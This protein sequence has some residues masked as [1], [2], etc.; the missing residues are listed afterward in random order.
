M[1]I[2][3]LCQLGRRF[4]SDD[5]GLALVEFAMALPVMLMIS[6]GG[7]ELAH[8]AIAVERVSQ[9]AM[10][11]ADNAARVRDSYT[12]ASNSIDEVD[13]NEVMTGAK[14]V[15]DS[16]QFAQNG[17]IILS[18]VENNAGNTGQW[19]RWQRCAGA[20]NVSSSYGAADAGKNDATLVA[21]VGPTGNKITASTGSAVMFV[22]VVYDYKP[23]VPL[24]YLGYSN[25]T[26]RFTAAFNVR[27]RTNYVLYNAKNLSGTAISSCSV[28][29]A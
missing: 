28:Y 4:R 9:I 2:E 29:S 18:S 1:K 10:T 6:L 13:V 20:K 25:R 22:E 14:Y 11:A 3:R 5:S 17:R 15:G 27:E 16:I 23:I 19:I 24:D 21:G 12:G 7:I 8:Y 26:L